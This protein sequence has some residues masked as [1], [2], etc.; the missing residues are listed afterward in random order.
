M[1]LATPSGGAG[2]GSGCFLDIAIGR[3]TLLALALVGGGF[4]GQLIQVDGRAARRLFAAIAVDAA[5]ASRHL[6]EAAH[7]GVQERDW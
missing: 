3:L 1:V 4:Q 7:T 2:G 5:E 6:V